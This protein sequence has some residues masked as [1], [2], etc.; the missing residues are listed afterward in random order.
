MGAVK[1]PFVC[2]I[3]Q[4]M[5]VREQNSLVCP[6]R[7]AF[8]VARQG[9]VNLLLKKPDNLYEDKALFAARRAVYEAGFFDP[10]V[11]AVA[12]RLGAGVLLDAGCGEGSLLTR[13]V[14]LVEGVSGIGL[15]IAKPAVQMAA[16]ADKQSAWCV[17]DLCNI[18]LADASVDTIVNVLTPA[19]YGEFMRVLRDGG[20]LVKVVPNAGHLR[21]IRALSGKAPYT[22]ALSETVAVFGKQFVLLDTEVVQY[23][24]P[25]DDALARQ[26]FDMTPL[27][28]HVET[29]QRLPSEVTV[30]VTLLVG[31]KK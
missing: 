10:V 25:C 3:C 1:M 26:V 18:P 19:N 21:E 16:A 6:G 7:H 8:D 17:G 15:D 31:T 29:L 20:R 4:G 24:M 13:L 28:T 5:F 9:Y 22:H 12:K 11:Q 30:D 14:R 27:T 2:P 23:V